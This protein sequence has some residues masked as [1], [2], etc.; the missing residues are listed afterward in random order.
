MDEYL[1]R[2]EQTRLRRQ[3]RVRK[4]VKGSGEKPRLSVHK[5]NQHL[6]A[7]LIDDEQGMTLLSVDTRSKEMQSKGLG[8][9][10]KKAAL[11]IGAKIAELAKEKQIERV[12]FDRGRFKYHGVIAQLA[13]AA[14][15][16]GMRF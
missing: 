4:R 8:K 2:R 1:K 10:S 6:Y 16:A 14:R 11:V 9:K 13:D 12:V 3:R 7:Q 15:E 5:S